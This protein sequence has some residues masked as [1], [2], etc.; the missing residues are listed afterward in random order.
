MSQTEVRL[1]DAVVTRYYV[2][3]NGVRVYGTNEPCDIALGRKGGQM[4][5][6][7]ARNPACAAGVP[8]H[9]LDEL[10]MDGLIRT[11]R[12][13]LRHTNLAM[14]ILLSDNLASIESHLERVGCG[15]SKM[16]AN[17]SATTGPPVLDLT[18][19]ITTS[20]G[21]KS[22]T[23]VIGHATR[24]STQAS[25]KVVPDRTPSTFGQTSSITDAAR[26]G[27]PGS[28]AMPQD[29]YNGI[30]RPRSHRPGFPADGI[31]RAS[32]LRT[33]RTSAYEGVVSDLNSSTLDLSGMRS[34]ISAA[35]TQL[36]VRDPSAAQSSPTDAEQ[37]ADVFDKAIGVA[38]EEFVSPIG[39]LSNRSA[40]R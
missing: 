23:L 38:G 13:P 15:R 7:V 4:V 28:G 22:K 34:L 24:S 21:N 11:L 33:G 19:A 29:V 18:K 2:V 10:G 32:R 37:G 20:N 26:S 30:E 12:I 8:Y 31:P 3:I 14:R 6:F 1:Y 39:S 5:I 40:L 27:Y 36:Y 35:T 16:L 9:D 25:S 17:G